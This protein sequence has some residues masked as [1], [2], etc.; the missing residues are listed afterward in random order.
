MQLNEFFYV[1]LFAVFCYSCFVTG[2]FL[3]KDVQHGYQVSILDIIACGPVGLLMVLLFKLVRVI[4]VHFEKHAPNTLDSYSLLESES[5]ELGMN[6]SNI[7][8]V[9]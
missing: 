2:I 6:S 3:Y 7:E 1:F 4:Y 9:D 5:C 8:V